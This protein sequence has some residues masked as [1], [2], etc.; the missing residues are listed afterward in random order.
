MAIRKSRKAV[1]SRNSEAVPPV[2]PKRAVALWGP[3]VAM[4]LANADAEIASGLVT[5][6][7]FGKM[8]E[9]NDPLDPREATVMVRHL[10]QHLYALQS[11]TH[12]ARACLDTLQR[13]GW[14]GGAQ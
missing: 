11:S 1:R 10:T 4:H 6:R 7:I 3:G 13:G 12:C 9:G 8:L 14:K 5:A 2:S